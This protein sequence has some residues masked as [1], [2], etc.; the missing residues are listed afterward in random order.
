MRT[1]EEIAF[2]KAELC[3]RVADGSFMTDACKDL[4]IKHTDLADWKKTD[5]LFRDGLQVAV[6]HLTEV[7]ADELVTIHERIADPKR[8]NVA[9]G[10]L[11]WRLAKLNPAVFGEKA[12]RPEDQP[13]LLIVLKAA[14]ARTIADGLARPVALIELKPDE[15]GGG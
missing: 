14:I 7:K 4:G 3:G 6:D 13:E 10:N 8:A 12:E 2:L 1:E 9:S 15:P 5:A 11:K